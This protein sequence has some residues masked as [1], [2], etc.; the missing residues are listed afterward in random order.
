MRHNSSRLDEFQLILVGLG[1]GSFIQGASTHNQ[2]IERLWVDLQRWSTN[3]FRA[4]FIWME[5][6]GILNVDDPIDLWA[7][8]L[9]YIPVINKYLDNFVAKWNNHG[10]RTARNNSP[11][12]LWIR[13]EHDND[14]KKQLIVDRMHAAELGIDPLEDP[15]HSP[16]ELDPDLE[17]HQAINFAEYGVDHVGAYA[18]HQPK[19]D[20]PYVAVD[21]TVDN[22]EERVRTLLNDTGFHV[23]LEQVA[24]SYWPVASDFGVARYNSVRDTI[25]AH[26]EL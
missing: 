12:T 8:H 13:S 26:L 15:L 24:G 6:E 20:D 17:R 7:L 1:R 11:R 18:T 10:I 2:R 19:D 23:H 16:D 5:N 3:R 21:G 25:R 22:A 14:V 9:C 4:L